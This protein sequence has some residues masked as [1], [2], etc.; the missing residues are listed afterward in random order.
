MCLPPDLCKKARKILGWSQE[1][2]SHQTKLAQCTV[3]K[4]EKGNECSLS[5]V[6]ILVTTFVKYG[7]AFDDGDV[8]KVAEISFTKSL[9][10]RSRRSL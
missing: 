3:S 10:G 1:E 7:L 2:L 6:S 5:T 4:F 8:K 9:D